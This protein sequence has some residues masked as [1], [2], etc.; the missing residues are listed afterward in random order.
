MDSRRGSSP[1]FDW[2]LDLSKFGHHLSVEKETTFVEL[3]IFL[4]PPF[5]ESQGSPFLRIPA[6][7]KYPLSPLFSPVRCIARIRGTKRCWHENLGHF[8]ASLSSLEQTNVGRRSESREGVALFATAEK[9]Q[10]AKE[11]SLPKWQVKLDQ[12]F[13][14]ETFIVFVKKI[15]SLT[16]GKSSEVLSP[17]RSYRQEKKIPFA[18]R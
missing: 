8:F 10:R 18:A 2:T 3:A 15:F 7:N 17:I 12:G 9:G 5:L 4:L 6:N 13:I 11:D 14:C 16:C 1:F